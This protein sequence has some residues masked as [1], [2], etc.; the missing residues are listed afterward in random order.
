MLAVLAFIPVYRLM[1]VLV[2]AMVVAGLLVIFQAGCD[3]PG[4]GGFDPP[5]CTARPCVTAL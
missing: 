5:F 3:L 1:A 2:L 4:V